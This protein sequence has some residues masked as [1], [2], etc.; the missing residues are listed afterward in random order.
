M[1]DLEL[2]FET[3]LVPLELE[4]AISRAEHERGD[5]AKSLNNVRLTVDLSTVN[6]V[7]LGAAAQLVLYLDGWADA[8][9]E[10]AVSFPSQSRLP[11]DRGDQDGLHRAKVTSFL[12]YIRFDAALRHVGERR[13]CAIKLY[14]DGE[15]LS[16]TVIS[17]DETETYLQVVPMHWVRIRDIEQRRQIAQHLTAAMRRN[18]SG[19][20]GPDALALSNV[21]LHELIENVVEHSNSGDAALVCGFAHSKSADISPKDYFGEERPYIEAT[22]AAALPLLEIIVGD[23]GRGIARTLEGSYRLGPGQLP[24]NLTKN[25]I[26]LPQNIIRWAFD[27]WSTERQAE[28]SKRGVRGLFRIDRLVA[29]YFGQVSVRTERVLFVREHIVRDEPVERTN[30][31]PKAFPH[32]RGTCIRVRMTGFT[33][34]GI[35]ELLAIYAGDRVG[36]KRRELIAKSVPDY[37]LVDRLGADG[38]PEATRD[39][40]LQ[41]ISN[42]SS[43]PESLYVC[44]VERTDDTRAIEEALRFLAA[45]AN[46]VPLYALN[47]RC[48]ADE[49]ASAVESINEEAGRTE[50]GQDGAASCAERLDIVCTVHHSGTIHWVGVSPS[51]VNFLQRVTAQGAAA[52]PADILP[53]VIRTE[54]RL[55]PFFRLERRGDEQT[56]S[57][58]RCAA[59]ISP[60]RN[61]VHQELIKRLTHGGHSSWVWHDG[62][63]LTPNLNFVQNWFRLDAMVH[64]LDKSVFQTVVFELSR[65]LQESFATGERWAQSPLNGLLIVTEE[66]SS[67]LVSAALAERFNLRP[68]EGLGKPSLVGLLPKDMTTDIPVIIYADIVSTGESLRRTTQ[69]VLRRG[70]K[71]AAVAALVDTR[72]TASYHIEAFGNKIPLIA[73]LHYPNEVQDPA[74]FSVI[75]PSL[76]EVESAFATPDEHL[77]SAL[78]GY[79]Q[80]GV[81][82]RAIEFRHQVRKN[83]RHLTLTLDAYKLVESEEFSS[84]LTI[85][86]NSFVA[87]LEQDDPK[88]AGLVVFVPS[89]FRDERWQ[90][91]IRSLFEQRVSA[92][93]TTVHFVIR[94]TV[95]GKV[96][97]QSPSLSTD[98]IRNAIGV[99]VFDWGM[100]SGRS[101]DELTD[102]ALSLGARRIFVLVANSQLPISERRFREGVAELKAN[103]ITKKAEDFFGEDERADESV[104]YKFVV[105]NTL[106][107]GFYSGEPDCPVCSQGRELLAIPC[108]DR[109]ID[110]Y[111]RS[112]LRML[113]MPDQ[114]DRGFSGADLNSRPAAVAILRSKLVMA[115]SE[116]IARFRFQKELEKLAIEAQGGLQLSSE[117]VAVIELL[118]VESNWIQRPPIRFRSCRDPVAVVCRAVI[119][120]GTPE[121]RAMA[122]WVLRKV[123][124]KKFLSQA[125][126]IF[127]RLDSDE[128]AQGALLLGIHTYLSSHYHESTAMLVPAR[129]ALEEIHSAVVTSNAEIKPKFLQAFGAVKYL[130]FQAE[131]LESRAESHSVDRVRALRGIQ[132][133]L[134]EPNYY[135]H[136]T[137]N[138]SAELLLQTQ[139]LDAI[140]T[141]IRSAAQDSESPARRHPQLMAML[142]NRIESWALCK[143]FL[144]TKILPFAAKA[145]GEF[146]S[147]EFVNTVGDEGTARWFLNLIEAHTNGLAPDLA[148]DIVLGQL[149]EF[150][151]MGLR[152]YSPQTL[153]RSVDEFVSEASRLYNT[154]FRPKRLPRASSNRL[155]NTASSLKEFL[156]QLNANVVDVLQTALAEVEVIDVQLKLEMTGTTRSREDFGVSCTRNLL[157]RTFVE[158]LKNV[159]HHGAKDDSEDAI[160]AQAKLCVSESEIEVTIRN[161]YGH[162]AGIADPSRHGLALLRRELAHFGATLDELPGASDFA[163]HVTLRRWR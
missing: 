145:K 86:I 78:H 73:L 44:F 50:E 56:A 20:E 13:G 3:R 74:K 7:D 27:R 53:E 23:S 82:P 96:A 134:S 107:L 36:Q 106:P 151:S 38:F 112:A 84:A 90:T 40:I 113:L 100:I 71:V 150:M 16:T 8:V 26:A 19:V 140:R 105:L 66:S 162:R 136:G 148:P 14:S 68:F 132:E 137:I 144:V 88:T 57:V 81:A 65:A 94:T 142:T 64:S 79:T 135:A 39:E 58:L 47:I 21:V 37:L 121:E 11:T 54:L 93:P 91:A 51:L 104:E 55:K 24:D 147:Q 157:R 128:H 152:D 119:D 72:K 83:G 32:F 52:V 158:L 34:S 6:W 127:A 61:I 22:R 75:S 133:T 31:A 41:R 139:F 63:Y 33:V 87:S 46:P 30:K 69:M 15:P 125:S 70:F 45:H 124:K 117:C 163:V 59:D 29:R 97:F 92:C 89:D 155:G 2:R 18:G 161:R 17:R 110:N 153:L 146:E 5:L 156:D 115:E 98:G 42:A 103:R 1:T 123:S 76:I 10:V 154:V 28:P 141:L 109:F 35:N 4:R 149:S 111:R 126:A 67:H 120:R 122:I 108:G 48:S 102:Y 129:A 62:P 159:H 9:K 25:G 143:K 43:R 130:S 116:T 80:D 60:F 49:L 77:S 160:S 99:M 131:F 85:A 12:R 138:D 118:Y 95:G 114:G 101:V